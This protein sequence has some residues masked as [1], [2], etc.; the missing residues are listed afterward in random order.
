[1]AA[2]ARKAGTPAP[3]PPKQRGAEILQFAPP[4]DVRKAFP[5][6]IPDSTRIS[7]LEA[8]VAVLEA[9]LA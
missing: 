9:L 2:K 1:M 5:Q 4:P 7:D 3:P 6:A 8:R